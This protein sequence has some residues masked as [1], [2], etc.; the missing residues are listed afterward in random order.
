MR[1]NLLAFLLF[2]SLASA[3]NLQWMGHTWKPST[4]HMAGVIAADPANLSIDKD[5]AL[6]MRIVKKGDA[7]SGSEMFTTDDLSFGTYQ[8][9]IEN[10]QIY[11]MDP[12]IVIGL[13]SYGPIHKIGADAEEE[14]DIEFSAWNN[15]Q[16]KP[17]NADFTVY[18]PTGHRR[19]NG[20]S[21]WEHNFYVNDRPAKTTARFVWTADKIDFYIMAGFVPI[22]AP[23]E[24]V[25]QHDTL[26][27]D[28]T[29]VPH[30]AL[31][32]G[33]NLW[34]FKQPPLHEWEIVFRRFD[35]SPAK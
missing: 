29:N 35:F 14:I 2:A 6:H 22:S 13:F 9:E 12:T 31:P 15:N 4:G 20:V 21:A 5:G 28:G 7:W 25:L 18:P 17:I 23:P 26:T 30:V 16:P 19:P 27:N 10:S 24:H 11:A 32:I 1:L 33:M 8:W 34:S 3:Q